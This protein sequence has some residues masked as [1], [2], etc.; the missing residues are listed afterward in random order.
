MWISA[1]IT[2]SPS[3]PP[4]VPIRVGS[5]LTLRIE[6]LVAGGSGLG[7]L[8]GQV[9]FCPGT[10]PDELVRIEIVKGRKGVWYGRRLEILEKHP[11]RAHPHCPHVGPCGGCQ[12]QH[13]PYPLQLTQKA[14]MLEEALR[15]IG[16]QSFVSPEPVVPSPDPFGYRYCLRMAAEPGPEGM[17][18]GFFKGGTRTVLP[19][20][21]CLLPVDHL[22]R[23]VQGVEACLSTVNHP[24]RTIV[25]VEFR[26]SDLQNGCLVILRGLA[27]SEFAVQPVLDKILS[28]PCLLGVV[29]EWLDPCDPSHQKRALKPSSISRGVDHLWQSYLGLEL[30]MGHRSFM[31]GNWKL[32]EVLGRRLLQEIGDLD[33]PRILELYAGTGPLGMSLA[34]AGAR[35]T[36]VEVNKFAV[37]DMRESMVRND[38]RN[39]R[40]KSASAETYLQ[41]V[42][43]R[44]FDGILLDPPR[45]GLSPQVVKRVASLK[46]PL[47]WYLSCDM[48]TLARDL[49]LLSSQ[50]YRVKRVLPYDMFPQTAHVETLVT[51][52]I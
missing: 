28:L 22:Q 21:R 47:V 46:I 20:D 40:V 17:H 8:D 39:F 7:R 1:P 38:I 9:V 11:D 26:W 18:L 15:R 19:I 25:Q 41:T 34:R 44:R 48:P 49:N 24:R 37:D 33:R 51:C 29:Y 31:Q 10:L 6:K 4:S 5:T 13:V 2:D 52:T 30:K 12:L 45:V 16:K 35:V 50:G 32:F 36:A 3:S 27:E 42:Q 43:A 23:I 14:L